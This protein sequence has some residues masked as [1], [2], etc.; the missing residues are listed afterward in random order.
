MGH[1]GLYY[2]SQLY[3]FGRQYQATFPED[4][5]S[6][7][8]DKRF[9]RTVSKT[10]KRHECEACHS[11]PLEDYKNRDETRFKTMPGRPSGNNLT[12]KK[13][14]KED[15][16][17]DLVMMLVKLTYLKTKLSRIY[18]PENFRHTMLI[19]MMN[20]VREDLHRMVKRNEMR[21]SLLREGASKLETIDRLLR[22]ELVRAF[23]NRIRIERRN[24][25]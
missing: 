13:V 16:M 4:F 12:S 24:E 6:I 14:K 1:V 10:S 17:Q 5:P 7:N 25:P 22:A 23:K 15:Q 2:S 20:N 18:R 21:D 11:Y 19:S 8:F 9:Y 3:D